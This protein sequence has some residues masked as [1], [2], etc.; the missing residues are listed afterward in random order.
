LT[1]AASGSGVS[2]THAS[3]SVGA[4]VTSGTATYAGVTTVNSDHTRFAQNANGWASSRN[5]GGNGVQKISLPGN[6]V[7]GTYFV[8]LNDGKGNSGKEKV[9]V[10]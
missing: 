7:S 6:M 2:T 10:Q 9:I 3:R 1:T 8:E 4:N 5:T